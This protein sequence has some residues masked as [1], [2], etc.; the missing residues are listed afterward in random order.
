M[1]NVDLVDW[2]LESGERTQINIV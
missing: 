1:E 2:T